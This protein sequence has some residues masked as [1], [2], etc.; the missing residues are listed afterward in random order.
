MLKILLSVAW[1]CNCNDDYNFV[2]HYGK[3]VY[4]YKI[5]NID[6]NE[7]IRW[8]HP[9]LGCVTRLAVS[10]TAQ[11]TINY[12]TLCCNHSVYRTVL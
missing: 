4:C 6:A 3:M 9:A 12:F 1:V 5:F 11:F 10:D 8:Q 2:R 7:F